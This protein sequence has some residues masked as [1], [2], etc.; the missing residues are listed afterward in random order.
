MEVFELQDRLLQTRN[1]CLWSKRGTGKSYGLARVAFERRNEGPIVITGCGLRHA[2]IVYKYLRDICELN[3]VDFDSIK[4]YCVAV[5]DLRVDSIGKG[6][7]LLLVDEMGFI[8]SEYI[9]MIIKHKNW[10]GVASSD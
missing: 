4:A 5:S 7:F 8:P 3:G 10:V 1:G 6:D 2:H 9:P